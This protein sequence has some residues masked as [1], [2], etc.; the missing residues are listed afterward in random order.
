MLN[1]LEKIYDQL[2]NLMEIRDKFKKLND[3]S[4][5]IIPELN[6]LFED[7]VIATDIDCREAKEGVC[8]LQSILREVQ[9]MNSGYQNSEIKKLVKVADEY[10]RNNKEY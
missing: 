4:K 8:A 6:N 5:N 1:N 3:E 9:N 10:F 7:A 2:D